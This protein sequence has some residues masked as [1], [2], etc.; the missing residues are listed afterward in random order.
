[1]VD[2]LRMQSEARQE[3]HSHKFFTRVR[4]HFQ[5]PPLCIKGC[6]YVQNLTFSTSTKSILAAIL[7]EQ[8]CSNDKLRCLC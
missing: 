8:I 3:I 1:M 2:F 7:V 5:F 4:L 6:R